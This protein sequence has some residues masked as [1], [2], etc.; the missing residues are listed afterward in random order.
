LAL[1]GAPSGK[2]SEFLNRLKSILIILHTHKIMKFL[3]VVT[4]M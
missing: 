1:Y 2:F 4:Y 3:F